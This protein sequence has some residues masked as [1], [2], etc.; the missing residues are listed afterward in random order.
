MQ[1]EQMNQEVAEL[2]DEIRFEACEVN[3]G[4]VFSIDHYF[5]EPLSTDDLEVFTALVRARLDDSDMIHEETKEFGNDWVKKAVVIKLDGIKLAPDSD[6]DVVLADGS[7]ETHYYCG[8]SGMD[9]SEITEARYRH[10][11]RE[12]SLN[13]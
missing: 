3:P 10:L 6:G 5:A 2:V 11:L 1:K 7:V 12:C 13:P 9:C 8:Y 4:E